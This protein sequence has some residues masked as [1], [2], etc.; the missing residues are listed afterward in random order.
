VSQQLLTEWER[1]LGI[2]IDAHNLAERRFSWLDN[3]MGAVSLA[4]IVLLG[5]VATSADLTSGWATW[6]V[7]GVTSVGALCSAFQTQLRLGPTAMAH[8][9]AARQYGMLRRGVEEAK[10]LPADKMAERVTQLREQWDNLAV[11]APNVPNRVRARA[12]EKA[13]SQPT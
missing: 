13:L 3:V 1:R 11:N 8:Q 9:A 7:I 5:T 2:N 10:Q 4:T 6:L 12:K